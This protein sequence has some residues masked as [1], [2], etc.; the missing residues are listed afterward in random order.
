M[1]KANIKEDIINN[2]R[3]APM[4]ASAQTPSVPTPE[5]ILMADEKIG[6]VLDTDPDAQRLVQLLG[7]NRAEIKNLLLAS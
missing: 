7:W 4:E 2:A 3:R 5:D 1:L 6:E